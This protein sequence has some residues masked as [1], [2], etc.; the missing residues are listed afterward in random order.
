[1]LQLRPSLYLLALLLF[2]HGGALAIIWYLSVPL[3][4]AAIITVLCL[5]SLWQTLA[6]H[7]LR[8]SKKA[9]TQLRKENDGQWELKTRSGKVFSARLRG[10]S[11][12]TTHCVLLNFRIA[13]KHLPLSVVIWRDAVD[14]ESF[15]RL[16][17]QL[18]LIFQET[19]G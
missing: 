15:R 17:G 10:D 1:M 11:I 7:V 12:C 16:R 5:F 2:L 18:R 3:L 9:I 4:L 6:I 14:N 19:D 8:N 13:G